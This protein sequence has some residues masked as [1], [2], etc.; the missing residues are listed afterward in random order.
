MDAAKQAPI[1]VDILSDVVCPWCVIGY[2]ELERAV[3]ETG[4]M[5]EVFWRPF[6]LNPHMPPEGQD[7]AEHVAQKY[8][9][10]REKSLEARERIAAHGAALGFTFNYEDGAR[11]VNTFRAHQLIHWAQPQGRGHPLKLALFE[12]YF[13]Q[14]R[15]VSRTDVLLDVAEAVGLDRAATEA[16][17]AEES[18]AEA[19]RKEQDA[20]R[21]HGVTAVPAMIFE[22]K[23]LVLGAKG[24]DGY[25]FILGKL[26]EARAG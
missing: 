19:V 11:M 25:R 12:A 20:W 6:E 21:D 23:H 8:G 24:V 1:R 15:D 2:K 10:S 26:L 5:V 16:V 7:L 17:L 13:T 14:G 3:L 22:R 18:E 9:T 4:L